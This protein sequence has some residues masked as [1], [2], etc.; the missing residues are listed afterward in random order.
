MLIEKLEKYIKK[1][2]IKQKF[3]AEKLNIPQE[4]LSKWLLKKAYP[5]YKNQ[6]K[7]IEFLK[8]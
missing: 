2:G 3:I 1:N 5:N 7:I 6:K 8:L 4:T